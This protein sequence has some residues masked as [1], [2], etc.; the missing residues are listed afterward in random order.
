VLVVDD[1]RDAA[2]AMARMLE[3]DGHQVETAYDGASAL[4][5]AAARPPDV[6][7]LDIGLPDVNGC[8]VARRLRQTQTGPLAIV[9]ISGW[10][11]Q[12]DKQQA[13]DAGCDLHLTKPASPQQVREIV[14]AVPAG[15]DI[16]HTTGPAR[17]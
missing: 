3:L 11:Q 1:N 14:A 17:P 4:S 9:A 12:R 8:E 7:L 6:A 5:S 16:T 2:D 13:I 10:G 15:G